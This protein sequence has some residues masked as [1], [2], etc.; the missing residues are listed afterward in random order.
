MKSLLPNCD[1]ISLRNLSQ[2][3]NDWKEIVE[4]YLGNFRKVIQGHVTNDDH[5]LLKIASIYT[6]NKLEKLELKWASQ[7]IESNTILRRIL[8]N[9]QSLKEI[10]IT[11]RD[12]GWIFPDVVSTMAFQLPHLERV[13]FSSSRIH[14]LYGPCTCWQFRRENKDNFKLKYSD[15]DVEEI[16][17]RC[18]IRPNCTYIVDLLRVL[19]SKCK[20]TDLTHSSVPGGD[21]MEPLM[22]HEYMCRDG[23]FYNNNMV[24]SSHD[25]SDD[26]EVSIEYYGN[27][28]DD[29]DW[30][31][32]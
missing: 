2:T 26:S 14:I 9:H 29:N 18:Q 16:E 1:L 19:H 7:K 28:F 5:K 15:E 10:N 30:Y 8:Q 20:F 25:D 31:N 13:S 6:F 11:I 23:M 27:L 17:Y 12:G 32:D 22:Y 4:D 24:D 21:W 3:N